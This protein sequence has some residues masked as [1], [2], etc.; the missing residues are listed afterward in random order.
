MYHR[1]LPASEA[2]RRF[3][4]PGMTVT[5][6]TFAKHLSWLEASYRVLP[7]GEISDRLLAGRPLPPGACAISFDDGWLD[8]AEYAWPELS[9]RGLPATIF[10]VVG[11]V[12]TRGAFWTDEVCR[13]LAAL[14]PSEQR[15]AAAALGAA[16]GADPTE[17]VLAAL[18]ALDEEERE[19]ALG[20][21]RTLGGAD[22][23]EERELLDWDDVARMDGSGIDFE[24]HAL[25]HAILTGLPPEEAARELR[26]AREGLQERGCGRHALLAYPSG[27]HDAAVVQSAR[28]AGYRAA[29]TTERGLAG[30]A[31]DPLGLPR[32]ALHDDVSNSRSLFHAR[33]P[34]SARSRGGMARRAT[35]ESASAQ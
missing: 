7:L 11:R 16:R 5:P 13:R 22:P 14:A 34:G 10:L 25:S 8:N 20:R 2:T 18:K 9:R 19:S 12:G 31:D 28:E 1:V 6:E 3:V 4:E 15:E 24:S 30:P 35:R 33:V 27:A 32:L 29:L 21:L 23:R 26:A 17:A